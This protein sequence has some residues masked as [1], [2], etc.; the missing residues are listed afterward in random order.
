MPLKTQT[1]RSDQ[2]VWTQVKLVQNKRLT[3]EVFQCMQMGNL[4]TL[5]Y[6]EIPHF[7]K[8]AHAHTRTQF[9]IWLVR[10]DVSILPQY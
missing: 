8:Y 4:I 5:N 9:W 7:H 10:P 6:K 3:C 2:S 1:T